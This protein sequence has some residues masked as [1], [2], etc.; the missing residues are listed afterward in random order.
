MYVPGHTTWMYCLRQCVLESQNLE[1]E[2]HPMEALSHPLDFTEENL[3]MSQVQVKHLVGAGW[4]WRVTKHS[5]PC[6]P[7]HHPSI[8]LSTVLASP[9]YS[10]ACKPVLWFCEQ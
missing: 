5:Y 9:Q 3:N 6:L 4:C 10:S 1:A 2:R 8:S 7:L